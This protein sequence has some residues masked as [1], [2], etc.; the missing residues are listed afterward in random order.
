[1]LGAL[2]MQMHNLI[3]VYTLI[4]EKDLIYTENYSDK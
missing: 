3:R 4:R 2:E 1:M